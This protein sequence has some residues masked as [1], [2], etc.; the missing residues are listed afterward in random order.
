MMYD[1]ERLGK[2]E[3]R[4][5]VVIIKPEQG[6]EE[7]AWSQASGSKSKAKHAAVEI[8]LVYC[9]LDLACFAAQAPVNSSPS[10]VAETN[11]SNAP[12]ELQMLVDRRK[13]KVQYDYEKLGEQEFRARVVVLVWSSQRGTSVRRS[14][15]GRRHRGVRQRQSMLLLRLT[16]GTLEVYSRETG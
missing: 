8:G 1:Y 13:C 11:A 7:L 5:R 9:S 12:M 6:R 16:S 14:L 4:A 3:L 2:Q 10:A 15:R